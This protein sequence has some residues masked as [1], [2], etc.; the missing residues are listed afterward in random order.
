MPEYAPFMTQNPSGSR[1]SERSSGWRG[2]PETHF[3]VMFALDHVKGVSDGE[4]VG[5]TL[6]GRKSRGHQDPRT[7]RWEKSRPAA[8]LPAALISRVAIN[9]C[10]GNPE[11]LR[12]ATVCPLRGDVVKMRL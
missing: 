2:P 9:V 3:N 1:R 8:L 12:D 5:A 6:E 4:H 11:L 7:R 10:A